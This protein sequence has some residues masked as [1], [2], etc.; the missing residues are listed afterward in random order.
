MLKW[1]SAK[2]LFQFWCWG[3]ITTKIKDFYPIRYEMDCFVAKTEMVWNSN[4]STYHTR[5]FRHGHESCLIL[6]LVVW[7]LL[8]LSWCAFG[9]KNHLPFKLT[10]GQFSYLH[11]FE[12]GQGFGI[13]VASSGAGQENK[14]KKQ[15]AKTNPKTLVSE[16]F[17]LLHPKLWCQSISCC[18]TQNP[19]CGTVCTPFIQERENSKT[20]FDMDCRLGSVK[21]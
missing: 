20:L 1:K 21:T 10:Q 17:L 7:R 9:F 18:C 8:C 11:S 13:F 3:I 15:K 4:P 19:N 12:L 6:Q 2:I 14:Q 5:V 16:H